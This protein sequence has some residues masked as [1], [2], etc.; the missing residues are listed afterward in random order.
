M[1]SP[2]FGFA[3]AVFAAG[4]LAAGC[5]RMEI[6][7]GNF[8]LQREV[9][10]VEAGMSR[11]AVRNTLGTPLLRDP[12]HPDRWDYVF[13]RISPGGERVYR[14]LTVIFDKAGEVAHTERAGTAFPEGYSSRE[15]PS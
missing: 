11:E 6:E 15:G 13:Y 3:A 1:S 4:M 7:Q 9:E 8:L 5:A 10:E 12:F 2:A 14:R